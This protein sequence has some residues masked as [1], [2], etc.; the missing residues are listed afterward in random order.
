[1]HLDDVPE[2]RCDCTKLTL[3]LELGDLHASAYCEHCRHDVW[4]GRSIPEGPATV[5]GARPRRPGEKS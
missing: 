5:R 4:I 1:M 3:R 2:Q